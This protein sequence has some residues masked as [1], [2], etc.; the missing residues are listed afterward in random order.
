MWLGKRSL[1]YYK[2]PMVTF[3]SLVFFFNF[4]LYKC[5]FVFLCC[6]IFCF[7]VMK[8]IT[9]SWLLYFYFDNLKF[10]ICLFCSHVVFN[11]IK[12]DARKQNEGRI[13]KLTEL[14]VCSKTYLVT[15]SVAINE[16]QVFFYFVSKNTINHINLLLPSTGFAYI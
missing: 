6:H 3:Y 8:I 10:H 12:F 11:R 1:H 15:R 7:T 2:C 5:N 14:T 13:N 16:S 9:Q 4:R